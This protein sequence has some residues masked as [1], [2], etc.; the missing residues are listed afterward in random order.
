M[1]LPS[2]KQGNSELKIDR[3]FQLS[4]VLFCKA[5]KHSEQLTTTLASTLLFKFY[6]LLQ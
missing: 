6:K 2:T 1:P 4:L 3:C 5:Q